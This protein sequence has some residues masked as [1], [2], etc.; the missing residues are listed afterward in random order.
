MVFLAG[1]SSRSVTVQVAGDTDIEEDE[2]FALTLGGAYSGLE[3]GTGSASVVI[4][5]DDNPAT[6]HCF[7]PRTRIATRPFGLRA[8]ETLVPGSAVLTA[9]GAARILTWAGHWRPDPG[10]AGQRAVRIRAHAFGPGRPGRDLVVSPGHGLWFAGALV[11]AAALVDGVRVLR[12]AVPS[13]YVHFACARHEVVLAEGLAVESFLSPERGSGHRGFAGMAAPLPRLEGGAGLE[14]LRAS[15][16]LGAPPVGPRG[17]NL[18]CVVA[19]PR[20][21]VVE[22]WASDPDGPARLVVEA[23][24]LCVPVV[25][26]RWRPDLDRAGLPAA[27]FSAVLPHWAGTV[28]GVRR[29][30]GFLLTLL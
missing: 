30:D 14:A 26:N 25:A 4:A 7:A 8:V 12:E 17:G 24:G 16:G 1:E 6:V 27:A 19:T 11:T 29:A 22:G 21:I 3:I 5:D 18:N 13:A 15:L 20:G 2:G 28:A 10:D 9:G 23:E